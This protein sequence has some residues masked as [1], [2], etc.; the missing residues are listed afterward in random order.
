MCGSVFI[1]SVPFIFLS[2]ASGNAVRM[3]RMN[4]VYRGSP[5]SPIRIVCRVRNMRC[6]S[7]VHGHEPYIRM[8]DIPDLCTRMRVSFTVCIGLLVCDALYPGL[9]VNDLYSVCAKI[10]FCPCAATHG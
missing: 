1:Y 3:K 2:A 7:R 10:F 9:M 4:V 6:D 5:K 8:M